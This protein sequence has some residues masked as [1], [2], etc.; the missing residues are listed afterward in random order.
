MVQDIAQEIYVV[1]EHQGRERFEE[2]EN[3]LI[4]FWTPSLETTATTEVLSY[5][6]LGKT[7][8]VRSERKKPISIAT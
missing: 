4:Y 3:P 5:Y 7:K 2:S 6:D 8:T 1:I